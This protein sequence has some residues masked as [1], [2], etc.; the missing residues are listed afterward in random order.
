M[1]VIRHHHPVVEQI[2]LATKMSECGSNHVRN[3]GSA[4]MTFAGAFVQIPLNLAPEFAVDLLC[5]LG[6]GFGRKLAQRLGVF[7]FEAK[8][9]FFRQR[10]HEPEGDEVRR[11]FA[12]DVRQITARVDASAKW[13]PAR[14]GLADAS[15]TPSACNWNLTR[16]NPGLGSAGFI[17]G[18]VTNWHSPGN[19]GFARFADCQSAT[20]QIANLRYGAVAG[21]SGIAPLHLVV[22]QTV[23]L[24]C[25]RLAACIVV[26]R[27]DCQ[28]EIQQTTSLR[29]IPLGSPKLVWYRLSRARHV[30][31]LSS[32]SALDQRER[33]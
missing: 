24:L 29:Y 8:Q 30:R 6:R 26:T 33:T 7:L 13:M 21:V 12:F 17:L 31:K 18:E 15:G 4:E 1:N 5:L 11:A 3:C 23:C 22:A 2:T 25:R 28:S 20:Q 10:I 19:S 27:A 14:S 9:H 32:R 16:S